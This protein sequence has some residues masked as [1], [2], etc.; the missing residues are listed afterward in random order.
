MKGNKIASLVRGSKSY[1]HWKKVGFQKRSGIAV[2][3][4]SILSKR[5]VG[6]GEF[7]DLEH[8][9]DWCTKNGNSIVQLLPMNELGGV[10]CP[11]DAVS[12]FALEPAYIALRL[13]P[14][15]NTAKY[16]KM[17]K[18]L[19]GRFSHKSTNVDYRI[20]A[21]KIEILWELFKNN[22]SLQDKAFKSFIRKNSFWIE[23]YALFKELKFLNG[24]KAWFDWEQNL[25]LNNDEALK[26]FKAEHQDGLLFHKWVQ[27]LVYEQ[28]KAVKEYA[29]SKS[30][31][32]KGDLPVLVSRDSADVWAHTK[33][34]KLDMA[35][36]A[37]P[38]M[39]CA[40]GQRWGMPTYNWHEI[41][42]DDYKYLISKLKYAENFYDI[43]RID[44][45]VGLFRIWSIPENEP[46]ENQGLNGFFDPSDESYWEEH[47]KAIL[48]EILAA[49]KMLLCAEDLG[50]VPDAC[51][52]TL[53]DYAI[54]GN[55][56]QRWVKDWTDNHTF[57]SADEYR[58]LSVAMLSTHDTTNWSAWWE[59]EAGTVDQ[60]LFERLFQE[61]GID[62]QRVYPLLFDPKKSRNGRLRWKKN[63][64]T[65]GDFLAVVEKA[66][67]EIEE[68]AGLYINSYGEKEKLWT[69]L[70]MSGRMKEK[71]SPEL[72]EAIFVFSMKSDAVFC[73]E[74]ILDLLMYA[75]VFKGNSYKYRLNLPGLV[76]D[77]NW[78]LR[79]PL[80]V[81]DMK[82]LKQNKDI[83]KMIKKYGRLV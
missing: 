10:N 79:M 77:L 59:N 50:V 49:S 54:P 15:A 62:Y 81:E 40:N 46:M 12:S 58:P 18:E 56:V 17:I 28:F 19:A 29:K 55:D 35:A 60:A 33:Y 73:I 70:G 2:P 20:R 47:G 72:L 11:Y 36:G 25:D 44:H 68:L 66:Q 65:I 16:K 22:S 69:L 6:I 39:Y 67:H 32:L 14:G 51:I 21:A 43:L 4:F 3:L 34:F 23:N 27:W 8:V 24:S 71:S 83:K 53:N 9:I 61:D 26:S 5:S 45:V 41:A 30:I 52:D 48:S 76:S 1:K 78:S 42:H 64:K 37:P 13:V 82:K 74:S 7:P 75:Q 38:D 57:L 80:Y 31:L 63:I